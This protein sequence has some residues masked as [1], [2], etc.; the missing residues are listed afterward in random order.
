VTE[1][2]AKARAMVRA[3]ALKWPDRNF[4]MVEQVVE[5]DIVNPETGGVSRSFAYK[6]KVDGVVGGAI[7]DWKSTADPAKY[8]MHRTIGYQLELYA[9]ALAETMEVNISSVQFRLIKT[10]Q[11]R[12]SQIPV[13]DADGLKIVVDADGARVLKANGAPRESG[14]TALGYVL[15]KE[16]ESGAAFEAR[17][18]TLLTEEPG[19]L[20]DE[21]RFLNDAR[22]LEAEKWLWAVSKRILDNRKT[23]FWMRNEHACHN[24]NRA[25]DYLPICEIACSGGDVSV[26]METDYH[27]VESGHVELPVAAVAA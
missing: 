10:P 23:G 26:I 13:L 25:C 5:K 20:I 21:D 9:L 15:T 3:V 7:I 18:F 27:R 22:L 19:Y 14:D 11:I 12:L 8:I 17:C 16:Y 24:F 2:A 1:G 6:G 4:D